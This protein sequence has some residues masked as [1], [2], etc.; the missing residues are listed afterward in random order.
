MK[1]H[2][3]SCGSLCPHGRRLINGAGGWLET[4]SLCCHC[5][6]VETDERLVLV[7]TGLGR[8]DLDPRHSRWPLTSRLAFGVRQNLADSAWQQV[9]QLG[10]RPQDVTDILLTHM[11]LDHAGGLSD[12]PRARVHV[13]VDELEAAL[14]PPAFRPGAVTCKANGRISPT[15]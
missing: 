11:D 1:V 10:Y 6:L 12:F 14:N 3:L 2:H 4:A 8:A 5:L 9:Q 7:D 15:G 13:F